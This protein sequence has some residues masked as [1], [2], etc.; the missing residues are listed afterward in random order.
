M[1]CPSSLPTFYASTQEHTS[2]KCT[3]CCS[4]NAGAVFTAPTSAPCHSPIIRIAIEFYASLS[5]PTFCHLH[6]SISGGS[7]RTSSPKDTQRDVTVNCQRPPG[8]GNPDIHTPLAPPL[9]IKV[10]EIGNNMENGKKCVIE[11][12]V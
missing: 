3:I 1:T 9:N 4:F 10:R 6:S 5:I 2:I 12:L 8:V 11:K 7:T